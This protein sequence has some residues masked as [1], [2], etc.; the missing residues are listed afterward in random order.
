QVEDERVESAE[1]AVRRCNGLLPIQRVDRESALRIPFVGDWRVFRAAKPVLRREELNEIDARVA[2]PLL[3][4]QID[5]RVSLFVDARLVG[6]KTDALSANQ[7]YAVAQ[8][9]RNARADP[10][11]R[12]L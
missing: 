7:M 9:N 10:R 2:G 6:K 12:K 4:E 5:V 11:L 8:Q 3:P 1:H